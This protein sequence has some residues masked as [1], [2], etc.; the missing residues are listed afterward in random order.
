M[1]ALLAPSASYEDVYSSFRWRVPERYNI[2]EDVCDRHA[3]D[4]SRVALIGE[5]DDGS[6]WRVTFREVQRKA[7]RLANALLSL[8]LQRGDRVVIMLRQEAWTAIA[9]IACWKAGLVSVPVPTLFGPDAIAYRVNHAGVRTA[10]TNSEHAPKL[11]EARE[12]AGCLEHVLLADLPRGDSSLE[13]LVSA[14]SEEFVNTDTSA[15]E[16]A[17]L[18][19]TSGTTGNPKGALQPHRSMIGHVPGIEFSLDFFPQPG[20]VMWSPADWSWLAG[21]MNVLMSAWYHGVPVLTYREPRFDA[22]R[23]LWMM[24]KYRVRTALITPTM[25][26]L[27]RQIPDPVQRFGL[28][29]SSR[30]HRQ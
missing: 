12:D 24:G 25:L 11:L 2:A 10:I 29:L 23:A 6:K 14:A 15:E 18:N 26:K 5:D 4:P 22:E 19:F 13:A 17:F 3:R 16:P 9:H 7:N 20:D 27:M 21:L 1:T 8:G 30:H 28:Q